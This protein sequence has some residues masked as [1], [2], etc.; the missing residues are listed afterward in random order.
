VR[1]EIKGTD[2]KE[3]EKEELETFYIEFLTVYTSIIEEKLIPKRD[4]EGKR[5]PIDLTDIKNNIK[6]KYSR[7]D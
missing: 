4:R 3:K 5:L 1:A 2:L 6:T 7:Q